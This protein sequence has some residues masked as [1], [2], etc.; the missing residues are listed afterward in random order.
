ML[1]R[2]AVLVRPRQPYIDW[3]ASLD[4][5]G[6]LPSTECGKTIYLVPDYEDDI[7]AM[8]ILA[9]CYP[10]IFEAE[11]EAWH[12]DEREWPSNRTFAMF[13]QWFEFE[14]HSI[15]EDICAD[16]IIDDSYL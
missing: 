11:L 3:A 2:S 12:T 13:R 16:P 4:D 14:F 15:V 8:E 5:E 10:I 6:I 9:Q 7:D 1:N